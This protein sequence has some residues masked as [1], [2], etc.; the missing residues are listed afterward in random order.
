MTLACIDVL[1]GASQA[2]SESTHVWLAER[3]L[4][5]QNMEGLYGQLCVLVAVPPASVPWCVC[6]CVYRSSAAASARVPD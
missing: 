3:G 5:V 4:I 1:W 2:H 6:V